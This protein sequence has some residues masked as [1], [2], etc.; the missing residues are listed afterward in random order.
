MAVLANA[1]K[2]IANDRSSLIKALQLAQEQNG[3]V[4]DEDLTEI[5]THF[6]V[7]PVDVEGIVSF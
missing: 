4:S 3:Y 7:P 1:L 5:S 2:T 6:K